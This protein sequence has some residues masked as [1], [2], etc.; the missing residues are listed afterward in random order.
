MASLLVGCET[1]LYMANRLKAYMEF[2]N[3]L[4]TSLTTGYF[5][6]AMTE[7][8]AHILTFLA[9]AIKIYQRPTFQRALISF[10]QDR[11]VQEFEQ[12][13]N[14]LGE[15]VETEASNC[16]R[17]LSEQDRGVLG[18]LQQELAKVL[19]KL[20]QDHKFQASL[21]RLEKKIDLKSLK[22]VEGATFDA[23]GQVHGACHP[24][25][26]VDLLRDIQDW[27]QRPNSKSIFWLKGMAGTGK[28]TISWT[29]A[30]WLATKGSLGVVD[31]G[32]SFFFKRGE[33]SRGSAALLFP[34]II[35]QLS[36]KIPGLD[37]LLAKAIES[38]PEICSKALGEQFR[39]LIS[40][41]LQR[42]VSSSG[43]S[44]FVIVVDALD[45]CKREDIDIVLQ[46]WPNLFNIDNVHL[47]LF[48]TS[49]PELPI[50]LGFNDMSTDVHHDMILHEV[51]QPIIQHDILAFLRDAFAKIR[52]DYNREPL[53]GTPL[54]HDWPGDEVLQQLTDMAIPLFIIAATICRFVHDPHWDPQE[55]LETIL[56]TRKIGQISQMAKTYLPVLN[57]MT[58]TLRDETDENR[59][60]AEFRT[61]VG[62]IV[63][64]AEPLSKTALAAL[65]NIPLETIGLRLRPLHSVLHIPMDAETPVRPLHLSFSEFL[66]SQELQNQPFGVNSPHTHGILLNKCLG[67]LSKPSPQ[68]LCENMCNLSYPGQPR[69]ELGHD[70][71]Q[72]RLPPAMQYAC[73]YWTHHAQHS[74]TEIRDDGEVHNFLQKH[75]LHWLEALSLI[76][77]ISEVIGYVSILQSLMSVSDAVA[78]ISEK[79]QC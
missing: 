78:G 39:T 24:A 69:R 14:K 21:E 71:V 26:R 12:D 72:G 15:R 1:A 76:N 52:K 44:M 33:D 2:L 36:K 29:I 18:Q 17:K 58:T 73:R 32:A 34:T 5:E 10:W 62:S 6:T 43:H 74:G 42:L 13:C 68:G 23:Y 37:V 57:Q 50:Q 11:D 79:D 16:D 8:Y 4:P 48:L 28:S 60:F 54:N 19:K 25:T 49:R 46:L 22:F 9:H 56:Q 20:E 64:L 77:K 7:L 31:L 65:L 30:N 27:A 55:R 61:V 38:N 41:P 51:P 47:R 45:E 70:I 63:T 40:Q 35:Y 67:L 66:T 59:L 75:F 3:K 53:R